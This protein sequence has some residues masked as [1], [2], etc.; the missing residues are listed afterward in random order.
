MTSASGGTFSV[1]KSL[2]VVDGVNH[3]TDVIGLGDTG[4]KLYIFD[5]I[6]KTTI[7]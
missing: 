7:E 2:V 5:L 6:F 3:K 4:Y 1:R